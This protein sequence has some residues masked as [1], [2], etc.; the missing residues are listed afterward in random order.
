[1]TDYKGVVDN[2]KDKQKILNL[3]TIKP[4]VKFYCDGCLHDEGVRSLNFYEMF[5][6]LPLARLQSISLMNYFISNSVSK[7]GFNEK[8]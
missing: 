7:G 3:S 5:G 4:R 6:H 2:V 1:M 8:T